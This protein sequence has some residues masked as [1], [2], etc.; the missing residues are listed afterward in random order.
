MT[1]AGQKLP[2]IQPTASSTKNS[3]GEIVELIKQKMKKVLFF[4]DTTTWDVPSGVDYCIAEVCGGG[5]GGGGS[6]MPTAGAPSA[7]S[8]GDG[9]FTGV[10]G[11]PVVINYMGF[12]TPCRSGREFSGQSA[13]FASGR[14]YYSYAGMIPAAVNEFGINLIPGETV[15]ITVGAGG[16]QGTLTTGN[17]G[18]GT[19][20]GEIG[21]AHV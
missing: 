7:V 10:G 11:D 9:V 13:F 19:A 1:R 8:C 17:P 16:V 15:T 4:S 6:S 3:A 21:R 18:P 14:S 12:Q 5:G 2:L 20:N